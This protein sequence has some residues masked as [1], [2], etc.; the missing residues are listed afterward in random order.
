MFEEHIKYSKI[1]K[2][3]KFFGTFKK[4]RQVLLKLDN[5]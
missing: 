2:K 4:T 3:T 5:S 1:R